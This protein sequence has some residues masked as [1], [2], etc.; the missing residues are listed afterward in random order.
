MRCFQ[1]QHLWV[2]P[3][4]S[5]RRRN[6][7]LHS[8]VQVSNRL[9]SLRRWY[10]APA[11]RSQLGL[12]PCPARWCGTRISTN[13]NMPAPSPL[14]ALWISNQGRGPQGHLTII[15]PQLCTH[16]SNSNSRMHRLIGRSRK[17]YLKPWTCRKL[18]WARVLITRHPSFSSSQN[19]APVSAHIKSWLREPSTSLNT[20]WV[21]TL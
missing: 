20:C 3:E 14:I 16:L 11:C 4:T 7:E 13:M 5:T 18:L 21:I 2:G 6:L 9:Y 12:R 10:Q 19:S 17:R 15:W 1:Y 8:T